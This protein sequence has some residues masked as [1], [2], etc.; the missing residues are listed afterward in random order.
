MIVALNIIK[1]MLFVFSCLGYILFINR[2]LKVRGEMAPLLFIAGCVV[3]SLI[4]GI[5]N[6]LIYTNILIL[7]VGIFLFYISTKDLLKND[8][9]K[10]ILKILTN[11]NTIC[12]T[13][14]FIYFILI[15]SRLHIVHYDNFT[16][17]A[18]VVQDMLEL[19]QLPNFESLITYKSYPLGTA[20]FIYYFCFWVGSLENVMIIA[21]SVILVASVSCLFVFVPKTKFSWLY[22]LLIIT[23][24]VLSS[25][26]YM[27]FK[28]LLVDT[29]LATVG[30][31]ALATIIYYYKDLKKTIIISSLLSTF[32][33]M[34]KNSGIYFL[35]INIIIVLYRIY[36]AFKNNE[37]DKHNA[38]KYLA[39]SLILPLSIMV[40]WKAH[41]PYAFGK[42]VYLGAH[43]M[44]IIKYG[45]QLL[46]TDFET[47]GK[48]TK[49]FLL[50]I[51]NIRSKILQ[52]ILLI[53]AVYLIYIF[54]IYFTQ[55]KWNKQIIFS[56]IVTDVIYIA[57]LIGT[58][59]MYIFSMPV[60]EALYL[61]GFDRY[62]STIIIYLIGILVICIMKTKQDAKILNM[63]NK[64][65]ACTLIILFSS[66]ILTSDTKSNIIG[67]DNY[68]NSVKCTMD[69]IK[70]QN[71][72]DTEDTEKKYAV[73]II[74]DSNLDIG[75]I[76]YM[77][78]YI[79]RTNNVVV[80]KNLTDS[81]KEYIKTADYVV[82]LSGNTALEEVL[83]ESSINQ[84]VI[85][86]K[87]LK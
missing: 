86:A 41:L 60:E 18:L 85:D 16:H 77:S 76:K 4:S 27:S 72:F 54:L 1:T 49:A 87:L 7:L 62:L 65:I 29:I 67:K 55:K 81:S 20:L 32:L 13:I 2:K 21:Q 38:L 30:L 59:V 79:F 73:C 70:M 83:K 23:F 12:I 44:S 84:K 28:E 22:R 33:I 35:V 15:A 56:W 57:Y 31:G 80:I 45:G 3:I 82:I 5:L 19:N 71:T 66:N 14:L 6:M 40:M 46:R 47:I 63:L 51:I 75:Y 58:Y 26:F 42:N 37:L 39:F 8:G 36:T 34:I 11:P 17:W 52:S 25:I 24:L 10:N 64:I 61:A 48:I 50:E 78:K 53:N 43:N 69:K 68:E 9:I 74:D